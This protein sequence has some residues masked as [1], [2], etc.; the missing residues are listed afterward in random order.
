MYNCVIRCAPSNVRSIKVVASLYKCGLVLE[1]VASLYKRGLR[2]VLSAQGTNMLCCSAA[3]AQ[4]TIMSAPKFGAVS[5][6][7]DIVLALVIAKHCK[8]IGQHQK[9]E[10]LC[11]ICL[12]A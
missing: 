3:V 6:I 12:R 10:Q 8:T 1:V 7:D 4:G 9:T 5:L 2:S 11:A